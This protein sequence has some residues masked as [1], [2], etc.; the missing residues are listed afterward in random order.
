M[1]FSQ[2]AS[3]CRVT[4]NA[5][6]RALL[7]NVPANIDAV[8]DATA[9]IANHR[10][11]EASDFASAQASFEAELRHHDVA[12]AMPLVGNVFDEFGLVS[13]WD[14]FGTFA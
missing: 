7:G 1:E 5:T 3:Q 10:P 14:K 2:G 6:S 13:R 11:I 12:E 9:A 4:G 8:G